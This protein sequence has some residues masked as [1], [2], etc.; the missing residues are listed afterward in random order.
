MALSCD[1]L[2]HTVQAKSSPG[3]A[4]H[5][6]H[7]ERT[8]QPPCG[9]LLDHRSKSIVYT[10]RVF[11]SPATKVSCGTRTALGTTLPLG[12][13]RTERQIYNGGKREGKKAGSAKHGHRVRCF[14]H[15]TDPP[16]AKKEYHRAIRTHPRTTSPFLKM[17]ESYKYLVR[18]IR[19]LERSSTHPALLLSRAERFHAV[20][21]L[22]HACRYSLRACPVG[23]AAFHRHGFFHANDHTPVE[24]VGK[25][26]GRVEA[27]SRKAKRRGRFPPLETSF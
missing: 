25:S 19:L 24:E 8:V 2:H 11:R 23:C 18:G 3:I 12:H 26:P 15:A 1:G 6:L 7:N 14:F 5:K 4:E 16:G 17:A 27:S 21:H 10:L 9:V 20:R 13:P 22:A